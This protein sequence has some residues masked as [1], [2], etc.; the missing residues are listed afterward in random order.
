[1][2][3]VS[4]V[5]PRPVAAAVPFAVLAVALLVKPMTDADA[6]AAAISRPMAAVAVS[7]LTKCFNFAF[8]GGWERIWDGTRTLIVK[9]D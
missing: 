5:A 3:L 6:G 1:M 4:I 8:D 2:M 9:K 7:V